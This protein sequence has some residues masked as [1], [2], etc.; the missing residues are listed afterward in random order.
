MYLKQVGE[1]DGGIRKNCLPSFASYPD[2]VIGT[3]ILYL[4]PRPGL[5]HSLRHKTEKKITT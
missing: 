5:D 4:A 1:E 2:L 3:E